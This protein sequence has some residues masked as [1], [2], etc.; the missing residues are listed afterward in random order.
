MLRRPDRAEFD[1]L[2]AMWHEGWRD[3]HLAI[4]PPELIDNRTP[5]VLA[6]RLDRKW[7]SVFVT[8]PVGAPDGFAV[9]LGDKLDQFYVASRLRGT[10]LALR[11]IAA[12]EAEF[13]CAGITRPSLICTV[14]NDRAARFYE[15]A[16]WE[17][18]GRHFGAVEIPGGT[19]DLPLWTF[20]KTL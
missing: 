20:E 7:P 19:F 14:G 9:L 11:F 4:S 13:L 1:P 5:E 3:A 10:G 15:K 18:T 12:V 8:G 6:W 16:G 2:V 17:N